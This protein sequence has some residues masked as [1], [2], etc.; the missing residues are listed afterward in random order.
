MADDS[1]LDRGAL[2]RIVFEDA[3]QRGWLEKLL[4]PLI[5]QKLKTGL[6]NATSHYSPLVSPLLIET[7]QNRLVQRILVVDIPEAMQVSRVMGRDNSSEEQVKA[8]MNTQTSRGKRLRCADDVI[9]N[10]GS[11]GDLKLAVSKLH[12]QHLK[13]AS[14]HAAS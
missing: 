2:R 12:Q 6:K 4:H 14:K 5:Y 1:S 10:D 13:M 11:L 8:I 7:G 3:N 9:V